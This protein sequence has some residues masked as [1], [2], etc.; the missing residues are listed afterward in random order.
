MGVVQH[1]GVR[2]I[3]AEP[4]GLAAA[5]RTRAREETRRRAVWITWQRHRRT[6]ELC[7]AFSLEL[8]ELTFSGPRLLRYPVVLFKTAARLVRARRDVVFIQCPSVV[9]GV[10]AGLLKKVVGYTLVADLHNEAVEP[11]NYTFTAY[12]WLVKW[13]A[14]A[15]DVCMVTNEPLARVVEANGGRPFVLPDKVPALAVAPQPR[16]DREAHVVFVCTFAPDEPYLEVIDAA[17]RLDPTVTVHITG[18]PRRLPEGVKLPAN[19]RLTGYLPDSDYEALLGD[20]DVIVDLTRMDNC[21]VCGAY[22]AVAVE[23]PLVTSN[24][25]ALRAYFNRGTVYSDHTPESLAEAINLGLEARALLTV[26]M[27]ELKVELERRWR[28]DAQRLRNRLN[29]V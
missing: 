15:A 5:A 24:T 18:N 20:A 16:R 17:G 29:I 21:L 19:V 28:N 10:W 7:E 11:Y 13:I 12:R 9:L 23:R 3:V 26:E 22:E 6:R 27:R 4:T 25:T 8:C 2:E 14:R 1:P